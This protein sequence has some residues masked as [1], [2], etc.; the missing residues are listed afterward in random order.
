MPR[1]ADPEVRPVELE[2]HRDH[3]RL[4]VDRCRREAGERLGAQVGDL[5]VGE[6]HGHIV[7]ARGL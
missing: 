4:T 3:V 5:V 2:P 7:L 1:P 6:G